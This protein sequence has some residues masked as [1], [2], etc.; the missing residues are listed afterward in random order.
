MRIL[1]S[2]GD[3]YPNLGGVTSL[4]GDI[5]GMLTKSGHSV[6]VLTRQW[7]GMTSSERW[8]GCP[9]VRLDYPMLSERLAVHRRLVLRSRS[10]LWRI[11]RLLRTG[12]IETV[13]IGLLDWSA[14]YLLFLRPF[15]RFELILYLHGSDTRVLPRNHR[16]YEWLLKRTL[17]AA[18]AVIAVSEELAAEAVA[19]A[20]SAAIKIRVI[21]SGV[22]VT[23]IRS[24]APRVH[25]RPYIAFLGRLVYEKDIDTLID[26]FQKSSPKIHG[27][28]LLIAGT[29]CEEARL[30]QKA[31]A[32]SGADRIRFLGRLEHDACYSLLKAALFVVLPSRTEGYPIVAVETR[33]AGTPLLGSRIPSIERVVVEGRTGVLF[34]QGD[35]AELAGL[36]ETYCRDEAALAALAAG[37]RDASCA[38][39]DLAAALPCHLAVFEGASKS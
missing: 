23:A 25:P 7:A 32:D 13:C 34:R 30:K 26:A 19:Y 37:A 16:S 5:A 6:T 35:A 8:N 33:V 24:A 38:E 2:S 3:Y 17:R 15:L 36:I 21:H 9:I 10:I 22:D 12:R 11:L 1:V 39:F 29:G 20:P 31:A 14:I 4:F 27:V 28:D 18:D